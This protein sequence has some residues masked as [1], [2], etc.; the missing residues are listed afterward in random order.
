MNPAYDSR[1]KMNLVLCYNRDSSTWISPLL[2]D[3]AVKANLERLTSDSAKEV[4]IV[5]DIKE[6]IIIKYQHIP[7]TPP[8]IFSVPPSIRHLDF[9]PHFAYFVDHHFLQ[10]IITNLEHKF[11]SSCRLLCTFDHLRQVLRQSSIIL[12]TVKYILLL[13][14]YTKRIFSVD[15]PFS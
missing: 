4:I 11:R 6:P 15:G 3:S 8:F 10:S 2:K 9:F 13:S 5:S 12:V 1:A 14:I 7:Y